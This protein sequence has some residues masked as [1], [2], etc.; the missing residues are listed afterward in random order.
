MAT[1]V[2]ELEERKNYLK[3]ETVET[4][5]FGGGTPSAIEPEKI[6]LVLDTIYKNYPLSPTPEI[7]LEANPDDL[8]PAYFRSL[9]SIG[10]NRLSIGVQSF[11]ERDLKWMNRRHSAEKAV[12]SVKFAYQFGFNNI[13]IDLIYGIPGMTTE[14]WRYNLD[15]FFNLRIPHLSAYHLTI[16]P[17]TVFGVRKKKGQFTEV[18][19]EESVA[20]FKIL[21]EETARNGYQHYEISNF[22]LDGFFSRHNLGYWESKNYLG[23]GPSAHSYDGI[24][25]RWNTKLHGEYIRKAGTGEKYYEEEFLSCNE[26]FND[27]ILTGLRTMWGINL[28]DIRRIFGDSFA[29]EVRETASR[30]S[31]YLVLEK[32]NIRL[33]DEGKF[34]A[35][36]ITSEFFRVNED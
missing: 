19:E 32:D 17:K 22:A 10:I 8:H 29:T 14:E 36:R 25:R 21:L 35:D 16:E 23:I 27:Y 1:I 13:N 28:S 5:Y 18:T 3:G 9:K 2:R 26:K 31:R 33:N 12:E 34:I 15:Q 4:I 24:S 11:L 6:K 30:Y 20:Q 7:T